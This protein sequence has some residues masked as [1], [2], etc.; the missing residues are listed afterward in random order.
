MIA[1]NG[2]CI[3]VWQPM[4]GHTDPAIEEEVEEMVEYF[5]LNSCLPMATTTFDPHDFQLNETCFISLLL[6]QKRRRE[7]VDKSVW[8]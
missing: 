4:S 7:R 8:N 1:E 5:V 6:I 3:L 2:V